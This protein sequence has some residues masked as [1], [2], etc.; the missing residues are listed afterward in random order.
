VSTVMGYLFLPTGMLQAINT[1]PSSTHLYYFLVSSVMLVLAD[2]SGTAS[3]GT[4][5]VL[6]FEDLSKGHLVPFLHQTSTGVCPIQLEDS[7]APAT[8]EY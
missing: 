2:T 3:T 4:I 8:R 5:V 1:R 7:P 6:L